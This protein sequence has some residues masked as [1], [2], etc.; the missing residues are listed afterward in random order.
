M[1]T[2]SVP[3]HGSVP[4]IGF[5][6]PVRLLRLRAA[7][8]QTPRA[9]DGRSFLEPRPIRSWDQGRAKDT[10]RREL[11][12]PRREGEANVASHG[13]ACRPR[14]PGE[15]RSQ[16]RCKLHWRQ[17]RSRQRTWA[18][19]QLAGNTAARGRKTVVAAQR[20]REGRPRRPG[21]GEDSGPGRCGR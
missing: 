1:Y 20:P 11:W 16:R 19:T 7:G 9:H 3:F 4:S 18:D 15:R 8:R 12:P 21:E 17:D 2:T 10:P 6:S 5:R 14:R 13:E